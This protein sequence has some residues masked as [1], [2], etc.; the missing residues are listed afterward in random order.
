M[1]I[2]LLDA[3]FVIFNNLPHRMV[4][5]EMKMHMA[6]P[7]ACFHAATGEECIEQIHQWMQPTSPFCS[8]FLREAIETLCL[9]TL[10]PDSQG[11][12]SQL[13]PVNLF[14]M[15]S[16]PYILCLCRRRLDAN[17]TGSN[18]LHHLPAPEPVCCGRPACAYSEW[19]A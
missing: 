3:G 4:I 12:L 11:R 6:S 7:E 10:T 13:G 16:G 14:A 15:V 9:D 17:Q 8:L 19:A 18:P 1:W 2:F 5:K